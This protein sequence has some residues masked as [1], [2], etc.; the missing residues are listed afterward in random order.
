VARPRSGRSRT[1]S[2][3]PHSFHPHHLRFRILES[4]GGAPPPSLRGPKGTV[5][6]P[7]GDSVRLLA[8]F[9]D[10]AGPHLPYMFHGHILE[11][12][13]RGMMGQFVITAPATL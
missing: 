2:G 8:E 13:D 1:P 5:Y 12:E 3:I 10:Y 9:G 6:M 4:A 7:P 11:H